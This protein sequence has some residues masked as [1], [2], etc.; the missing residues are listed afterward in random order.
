MALDIQ[1]TYHNL[2]KHLHTNTIGAGVV[3]ATFG[4][5]G[6]V[7]IIIGGA[8]AGGLT[9]AQTISWIFA[10]YFFGGLFGLFMSLK[11]KQPVAGAFSIAGAVLVVESLA[12][13]S[14]NEAIGAYLISNVMIILLGVTGLID[15]VMKRIPVPIVM[16]MIVGI[17]IHFAIDMISS[18]A[19]SPL[20]AGSAI[21]TFLL[22]TRFLK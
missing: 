2:R 14:I 10:V 17:L 22:S 12:N 1:A 21:I 8:S 4:A 3:A 11:Y 16:G 5:T 18:I 6:P 20:I 9:Y 15:M 13:Y 7:L 19:I